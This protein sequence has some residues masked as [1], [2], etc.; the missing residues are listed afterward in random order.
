MIELNLLPAELRKKRS[1][2]ELP[3]IPLI[4]LALAIIGSLVLLQLLLGGLILMCKNQLSRADKIWQDLAPEKVELDSIKLAIKTAS[5]KTRAIEELIKKRLSWARLLNEL[6]SSL[7]ANIWLT[8]FSYQE[9]AKAHALTLSGSASVKGD[10]EATRDIARFIK[11][12][13]ANKNFF[14]NFED[15][16]LV[17]MKKSSLAKQELMDFTLSCRFKKKGG[18]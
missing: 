15:I 1:R 4:P 7:T 14:K 3:K 8:D 13:K 9:K 12:L 2:I 18:G 11:A 17:S 16:E 6:S 10:E 5:R